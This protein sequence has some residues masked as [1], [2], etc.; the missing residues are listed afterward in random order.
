MTD[1]MEDLI[2]Q[3]VATIGKLKNGIKKEDRDSLEFDLNDFNIN[4]SGMEYD[5]DYGTIH[6]QKMKDEEYQAVK[7]SIKTDAAIK[8][9]LES[10]FIWEQLELD[11][12]EAQLKRYKRLHAGFIRMAE[13][14]KSNVI[15]EATDIKRMWF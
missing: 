14:V 12:T 1:P 15:Q 4:I 11:T 10:R 7:E 6:L 13:H 3:I 8:R 5:R 2:N 9:H